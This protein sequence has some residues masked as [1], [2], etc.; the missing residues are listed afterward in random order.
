M[1]K[2]FAGSWANI[3]SHP[4][5]RILTPVSPDVTNDLFIVLLEFLLF[6]LEDAVDAALCQC[7]S[8]FPSR[9]SGQPQLKHRFSLLVY[10]VIG[11][12]CVRHV[13]PLQVGSESFAPQN[14]NLPAHSFRNER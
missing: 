1:I 2:P 10:A 14:Q 6:T 7:R 3:T 4:S 9:S 11:R 5:S 12:L 8:A 13:R